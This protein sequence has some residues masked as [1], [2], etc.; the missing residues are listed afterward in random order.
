MYCESTRDKDTETDKEREREERRDRD[1][2]RERAAS[3]GETQRSRT[4]S[5]QHCTHLAVGAA[6]S[7]TA[8]FDGAQPMGES[9]ERSMMFCVVVWR[10]Q[11]KN[12]GRP[13][14]QRTKKKK[15][16]DRCTVQCT[17]HLYK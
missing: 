10:S 5:E 9:Q 6:F 15:D 8:G 1:R 3:E 4:A 17:T 16:I 11:A 2:D 13:S 14:G 12:A 7:A